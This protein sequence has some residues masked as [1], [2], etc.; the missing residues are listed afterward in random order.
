MVLWL[1][2]LQNLITGLGSSKDKNTDTNFVLHHQSQVQLEAA[3]RSDWL[4]RKVV[5]I[6]PFDMTREWRT[7]RADEDQIQ[8]LEALEKQLG[9]RQKVARAL[10]LSRLYGGAV[11]V[12]GDGANDPRQELRVDGVKKGGLRYLHVLSRHEIA[13]NDVD[14]DPVSPYFG[15]PKSY[16][17]NSASQSVELHPSRVVRFIGSPLPSMVG[18]EGWGD[19]ILQALY[20]AIIQASSAQQHVS[21][22]IPEAKTDIISMPGLSEALSTQAGTASV[23][24]RF[25]YAAMAKGMFG[26]L[27]IEGDGQKQGEVWQQKQLNFGAF[28]DLMRIFLQVAAGAADIPVTRL[29]G[30]SPAGMSATGESDMRNY[31]D[32]LRARQ[33][34]ELGP[35][36]ARLDEVLIRSA[37]GSR[38]EGVWYDW[39]PLWQMSDKEKAEIAKS[40][41]ETAAI[42][43]REALIPAEVLAEGV[44]GRLIDDGTFPGIEAAYDGQTTVELDEEDDEEELTG[45]VERLRVAANDAEPAPLY[46]HRKVKNGAAIIAWAKGQGF[47]STLNA[48]DLHVTIAFSRAPVDWMK[49]GESWESELKIAAGGPRVME[50][51]GEASVLLIPGRSLKW[52]HEEI[53]EAGASWDHPEYQPHITIS[54][55]GAPADLSKVKPYQ[56]EIVL[57]PEIF[58]PL[59]ED[60]KAKVAEG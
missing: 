37:L 32:H 6:V 57:G 51:F 46:V 60:W 42:Y 44:K 43:A 59:D 48:D 25:Q 2:R 29:L 36:L 58:E 8:A 17:I 15:E 9:I 40:T 56:G 14:R 19:S 23:T 7:W 49:V 45:N 33:V 11:L 54:Y 28:P 41:A 4:A 50:Q 1:D 52:R 13:A 27:L 39:A 26:M 10:C 35:A 38:P 53:R 22:L 20:D 47:T 55:G 21:G 31:H 5:D 30:Q 18:Y 34:N 3:Y 16:Q 24:N 12:L